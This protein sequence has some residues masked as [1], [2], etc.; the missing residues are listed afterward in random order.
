MGGKKDKWGFWIKK[1][2][3]ELVGKTFENNKGN[4]YT[5]LN[6]LTVTRYLIV[7]HNTG[8]I[9]S[10]TNK[11]IN[12]GGVKD[13]YAPELY[14]VGYVGMGVQ[15]RDDNISIKAYSVWNNMLRRCYSEKERVKFPTYEGCAVDSEWHCFQEYLLWFNLNYRVGFH[16][17]KDILSPSGHKIYSKTTCEFIPPYINSLFTDTKAKR[18]AYPQGVYY[19]KKNRKFVAQVCEGNGIQTHLGLY[20]TPE[21]AY[22][23]YMEKKMEVSKKILGEAL[24]KGD[25][26]PLFHARAI[27]YISNQLKEEHKCL[28]K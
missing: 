12:S 1:N 5:V 23:V 28:I 24:D 15:K 17:D 13:I 4:I 26:S 21:D 25:I 7:F 3:P 27:E 18:G 6:R 14:G 19:K 22:A 20:E 10:T 16:V 2:T 8:Y 11:E 9:T